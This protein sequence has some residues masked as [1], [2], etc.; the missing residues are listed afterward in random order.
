SN[1][2]VDPSIARN[3]ARVVEIAPAPDA[4]TPVKKIES[5]TAEPQSFARADPSNRA[6]SM[7]SA[8]IPATDKSSALASP[9]LT[10]PNLETVIVPRIAEFFAPQAL[11]QKVIRDTLTSELARHDV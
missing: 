6:D 7:P 9:P 4:T 1:S 2:N 10:V 3:T 5:R 11:D 8:S